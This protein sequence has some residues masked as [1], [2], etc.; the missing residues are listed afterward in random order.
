M[1]GIVAVLLLGSVAAGWLHVVVARRRPHA[2]IDNVIE[3]VQSWWVIAAIMGLALWS[4][5]TGV[6]VVFAFASWR[7]LREFLPPVVEG[8]GN[9]AMV[10]GAFSLALPAQYLLV[11]HGDARLL[12]LPIPFY[13]FV[14]LPLVA[15]LAGDARDLPRRLA[16]LQWGLVLC[17][18]GISFV[19]ALL[20][21]PI[22]GDAGRA[23]LLVVFLLLVTQL[24]DVLQY[25]WGKA[26]GRRAL[27]P[28]VSPA[29]T[30]EGLVGGVLS[31]AVVAALLAPITPFSRM[32]AVLVALVISLLGTLGGLI[33][34]AIKRDRG[35]KDWGS[36]I[37]G[38]GGM[39]DRLD[40]LCLSA[41]V[42][43]YWVRFGW[44]G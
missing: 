20:T 37:R 7:A 25:L 11:W 44:T 24:G 9:R 14:L 26:A 32:Q 43:Y 8:R 22:P 40:S 36:L 19:P 29:K 27:A 23:G 30:V 1:G 21:L 10:A 31:A 34:S 12:A 5:R 13:A 4:G 2:V 16:P 33:L 39:L 15:L 42:F 35:I 41:P 17:V 6:C 38:H 28:A 3:R 18:F